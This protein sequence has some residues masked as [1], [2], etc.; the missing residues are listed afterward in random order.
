M[1][2][3]GHVPPSRQEVVR[4]AEGCGVLELSLAWARASLGPAPPAALL[5]LLTQCTQHVLSAYCL[6]KT[7]P[8]LGLAREAE[9][10][11]P[12]TLSL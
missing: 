6:P 12:H 10:E 11:P 5:G 9:A 8:H 7:V 3:K 2:F 4:L 1:E